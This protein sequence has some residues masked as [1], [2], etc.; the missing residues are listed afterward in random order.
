MP[1][2]SQHPAPFCLTTYQFIYFR[3]YIGGIGLKDSQLDCVLLVVNPVIG[4][5]PVL[6]CS[7][8]AP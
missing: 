5:L 8:M 7:L 1:S 2:Q 3:K 4:G 6:I